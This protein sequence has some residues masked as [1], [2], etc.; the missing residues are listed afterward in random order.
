LFSSV[1]VRIGP[2]RAGKGGYGAL[3]AS[4]LIRAYPLLA[5]PALT[6]SATISAIR[7]TVGLVATE[8]TSGM[9][10]AWPT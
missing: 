10:E 2:P 1:S 7:M 9:I 6:R 3:I 4:D 5:Q 8:G